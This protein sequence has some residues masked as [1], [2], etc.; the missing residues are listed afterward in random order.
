MG[1]LVLAVLVWWQRRAAAPL[2]DLALFRDRSFAGGTLLATIA[3]FAFFGL[4]F[5]LP[6]LFQAVGGADAFGAGL[7]LLPV[8]GGLMAGARIGER[9]AARTGPRVVIAAGLTLMAAALFTGA[10]T[11]AAAGYGVVA[12]WISVAGVGL[13]L[14]MP[15]SMNVAISAL[16]AERSG[17][18]NALIQAVRQVG[19]AIGVA[20]LG[21]A[22][23]AGYRSALPATAGAEFRD[24]AATGTTAAQRLGDDGLLE[25]VR[26]AFVHGMD[27][28]LILSGGVAAAGV[29]LALVILPRGARAGREPDVLAES[30]S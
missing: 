17:V 13:G 28:S 14:T 12:A 2:I 26:A 16:G 15:T 30:G 6:Q 29:V 11:D 25:A 1:V 19:S 5:A 23:N 24:S 21:T 3:G 27:L 9:L 20:V 4:L 8:I 10:A 18:G 22:L 7:R